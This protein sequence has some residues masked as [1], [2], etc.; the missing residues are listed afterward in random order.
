MAKKECY[1][2][3][4]MDYWFRVGGEEWAVRCFQRSK[5]KLIRGTDGE[6]Q[7]DWEL[8]TKLLLNILTPEVEKYK[9]HSTGVYSDE[10]PS[11]YY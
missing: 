11:D 1:I 5:P 2:S 3:H 10:Y 9:G 6:E 8:L 7:N 4:V